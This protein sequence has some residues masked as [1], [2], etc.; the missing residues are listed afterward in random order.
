ML[1][2]IYSLEKKSKNVT[3]KRILILLKISVELRIY[4]FF[5]NFIN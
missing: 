2:K 5:K 3:D 1:H 4:Q